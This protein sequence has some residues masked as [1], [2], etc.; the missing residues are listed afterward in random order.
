MPGVSFRKALRFGQKKVVEAAA[1]PSISTL[2]AKLT[3]GYGKTLTAC[4]VYSVLKKQGRANRMLYIVPTKAQLAQFVDDGG[5]DLSDAAVDGP[6]DIIDLTYFKAMALKHHRQNTAQVFAVTVQSIIASGKDIIVDLLHSGQWFIVVDEYHHYGVDARWGE[7]V[8]ALNC[9][10]RLAMSATPYR[11]KAD[12]AFG[13]PDVDVPYLTAVEEGAVKK[14]SLHKYVYRVDVVDNKTKDVQSFTPEELIAF[15][16][17]DDPDA[18][19]QS[20]IE[21]EMRWSP[22]YVSPLV[23]IPIARMYRQR[24]AYGG[25]PFQV[26]VGAMSCAHARLVCDQIST[27]HPDLRV[28]WVGTGPNGRTNEENEKIL[29]AFCPPKRNGSRNPDDVNLDV[30]VHVGMAGEGLDSVFVTEVVHCNS[31]NINNSNHQENGRAARNIP[32]V[33]DITGH[34]NVDSSSPYA[35]YVGSAIM[36]LMDDMHAEVASEDEV[37]EHERTP[38]IPEMPD[39]P[40]VRSWDIEFIGV[41]DGDIAEAKTVV[42]GFAEKMDSAMLDAMLD[43]SHPDH[44]KAMAAVEAFA[45]RQ[46]KSKMEEM[47]LKARTEY[48]REQVAASVKTVANTAVRMLYGNTRVDRSINGDMQK[49]VNTQKKMEVGAVVPDYDVLMRHWNWLKDLEVR[50]RDGRIPS[51]L[52]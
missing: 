5:G 17:S 7:E 37:Q 9:T 12:S 39:Q 51:W 8:A 6:L 3:T 50:V 45:I 36:R 48:L 27:M 49:R 4:C 40:F 11:V 30:L 46:K 15:V 2:N 16:G 28:D 52:Q 22:K 13:V 21:N 24:A 41:D 44:E 38:D 19:D 23:S 32:G 18:I 42:Q 10:F 31:A 47:N 29:K 26:L 1:N 33:S 20:L 25:I 14:L 34:I 43:E 35:D